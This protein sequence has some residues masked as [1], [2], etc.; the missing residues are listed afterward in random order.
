MNCFMQFS[1][2]Y[3]PLRLPIETF[4]GESSKVKPSSIIESLQTILNPSLACFIEIPLMVV[5]WLA[6]SCLIL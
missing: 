4:A 1:Y 3:I 5:T 2:V 6:L